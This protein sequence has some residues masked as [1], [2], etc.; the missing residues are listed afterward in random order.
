MHAHHT[1]NV[2][3][4]GLATCMLA[5]V[6]YAASTEPAP[7]IPITWS[8]PDLDKTP[9]GNLP[10]HGPFENETVRTTSGAL[11][12]HAFLE[13][14]FDLLILRT[15][16][17]SVPMNSKGRPVA[18]GPDFFRCALS[19]GPTLMYTTFSNRPAGDDFQEDSKWQNY[20]SQVPGTH[21]DPQTGAD[22][23]N[24]LGY[25]YP[26]LGPPQLV[27]MDATYHIKFVIPHSAG[28]AV[29]E[30]TA[31]NLSNFIDENW[32]VANL[33][34]RVLPVDAVERVDAA[35]I[36]T[37]F[38]HALDTAA[39]DQPASFQKLIDGMDDTADWIAA[40]VQ[41]QP[42]DAAKLAEAIKNLGADD[43]G[44][45]SANRPPRTSAPWAPRR[46]QRC[47]TPA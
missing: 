45:A 31:M 8:H 2:A 29:V 12:A 33:Q 6:S 5:L 30:L 10:F 15:W 26:F 46:N 36:A 41:A 44:S 32:G 17:G 27:P 23:K 20:P 14:S 3:L 19:G 22:A 21:V 43:S 13:V 39:T 42:I 47:A 11:P 38:A 34:M 35:G 9:T 1:K 7:A 28:Q 16:D 25:N 4:I 18:L 24:S 40:N 37:A